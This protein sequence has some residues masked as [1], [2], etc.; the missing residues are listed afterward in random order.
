MR[1]VCFSPGLPPTQREQE[2]EQNGAEVC[3]RP[4]SSR[5]SELSGRAEWRRDAR[6]T[7]CVYWIGAV[8]PWAG[9]RARARGAAGG[10]SLSYLASSRPPNHCC[11]RTAGVPSSLQAA[12]DVEERS[13]E[14]CRGG[15]GCRRPA[16]QTT[17]GGPRHELEHR[18]HE[19]RR[20]GRRE[21]DRG[22][23]RGREHRECGGCE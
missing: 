5:E 4:S 10:Q 3:A 21:H 11:I 19:S 22:R 6:V 23:R 18:K 20:Q 7:W 8:A 13:Q 2:S 14:L 1:D 16:R 12:E 9:W 15:R 17:E